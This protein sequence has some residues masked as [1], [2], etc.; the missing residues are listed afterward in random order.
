MASDT[1][2]IT[3]IS[4]FIAKHV[5]LILLERGYTVRGTVRSSAKGEEV[6]VT[7]ARHGAAVDRL[8]I[9]EADLL[10]DAGWAEAAAGCRFVVH[11]ASPFPMAQPRDRFA[12][13]PA[14][15]EGTLRVIGAARDAGV[16][17]VVMTSSIVA[18]YQGHGSR[19]DARYGDADWSN[20]NDPSVG[21][22][23]VSKTVAERAAWEATRGTGLE[24]AVI[25]PAFVL[26]PLLD[27]DAGTSAML[28][29]MMMRGRT[30][31][32]P[33]VSFGIVDVRDVAQAHMAAMETPAAAGHRF[34]LS[35]GTRSLIEIG[36][37]LAA[38]DPTLRRRVPRFV[39]PD[40]VVRMASKVSAQARLL[41]LELG[42]AKDLDADP[43]RTNLAIVFRTPEE[44]IAA[45]AASLRE[46]GLVR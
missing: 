25:N 36:R 1:V 38:A 5:A 18:V 16:E 26:G 6:R 24:L 11:M 39:L 23:A 17:R 15:R 31:V 8:E 2:L 10:S 46:Y 21:A 40:Y 3:G 42:R 20:T 13:V 7:L 45:T 12:L 30:P 35:A 14:A 37:H 22:Y 33:D 41:V 44:A 34:I 28:I 32:V 43:A 29:A 19:A 9:I 4:G 27:A